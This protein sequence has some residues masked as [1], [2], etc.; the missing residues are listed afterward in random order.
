[1]AIKGYG[2]M[3]MFDQDGKL[4]VGRPSQIQFQVDVQNRDV[5]GYPY[6]NPDGVMQI[7]DSFINRETF[8][9][10]VSTAS[11][12]KTEM[13]R[14]FDQDIV[15]RNV[16]LPHSE[17]KTISASPAQIAVTGLAANQEVG[18]F[19]PSDTEPKSLTQ[20]TSTPA[21]ADEFQVTSNTIVFDDANAGKEAI[22]N[23]FKSYTNVE[24]IGV[25]SSPIGD[26]GFAGRLIGPRFTTGP[27]FYIPRMSRISGFTFGGDTAQISYR[28]VLQTGFAK[29]I[30]FAFDLPLTA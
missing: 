17:K 15:K 26:V 19:L 7:V 10:Q 21:S 22:I 27:L 29:P 9:C 1:M 4:Y 3:V 11:F 30:V 20:S 23:Y 5:D 8:N 12:D 14:V 13:A 16:L 2:N 25:E 6:E 18:V 24:T 28:A